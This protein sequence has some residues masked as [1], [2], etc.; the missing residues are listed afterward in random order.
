MRVTI[1]DRKASRLYGHLAA[2][3]REAQP[4]NSAA[5]NV[6][7]VMQMFRGDQI[8]GG[9]PLRAPKASRIDVAFRS[10]TDRKV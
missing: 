9:D 8:D 2:Q 10:W 7:S 6:M 4:I 5:T 3:V 1:W